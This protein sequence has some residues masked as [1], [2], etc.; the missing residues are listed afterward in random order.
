MKKLEN[1]FRNQAFHFLYNRND[2]CLCGKN[3]NL[4]YL[5]IRE[6]H[7]YVG[8]LRKMKTHVMFKNRFERKTWLKV[9][10]MQ[11]DLQ[12]KMKVILKVCNFKNTALLAYGICIPSRNKKIE[13]WL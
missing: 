3:V 1:K 11:I 5:L 13:K 2:F 12:L 6:A 9:S 4:H 8:D 10:A 7:D